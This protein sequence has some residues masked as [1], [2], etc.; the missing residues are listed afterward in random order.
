M[1]SLQNCV[2]AECSQLTCTF[3]SLNAD[4]SGL[5]YLVFEAQQQIEDLVQVIQQA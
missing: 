3:V 1:R 4:R 2:T 5:V